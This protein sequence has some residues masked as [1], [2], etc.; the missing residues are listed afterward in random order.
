MP[1]FPVVLEKPASKTIDVSL[2]P[3]QNIFSSMFLLAKEGDGTPGVHDWVAKTQARM[4]KKELENHQLAMIGFFFA[5]IPDENGITFPAYL[6]RLENT[7]PIAI[8]DKLLN[9]YATISL[10]NKQ[11]ESVDWDQVLA[12]RETYIAFLEERFGKDHVDIKLERRA[13]DLVMDPPALKDFL[14]THLNWL[15]ENYL[16]PEWKRVQP[17]V[18]ESVRAFKNFDLTSMTRIEAAKFV[19]GQELDESRWCKKLDTAERIVFVPNPH[20]G[21]YNHVEQVGDTLYITFGARQPEGTG[22]RIPELDRNEIVARLSALA[23]DTRLHIL[24]LATERGELRVQDIMEETNLSQPSVSRYLTQLTVT[25]YLQER[26]ENGSK[27][28]VLNEGRIEKT[29]KA[30]SAFLLRS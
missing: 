3:T 6:V 15:W 25:G 24:Q 8:K 17:M 22:E 9:A 29:L 18:Q 10:E 26:R 2:V 5:L 13:Y 21:P 16:A 11:P 19:T 23:D 20:I 28:Y 14:V 30:V 4:K 1:P 27:V 12:S 7:D